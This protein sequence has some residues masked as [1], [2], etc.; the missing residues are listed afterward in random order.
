MCSFHRRCCCSEKPGKKAS[1]RGCVKQPAA[2]PIPSLFLHHCFATHFLH[3]CPHRLTV[4]A[5]RLQEHV[6]AADA[7]AAERGLQDA[8]R[9]A[10]QRP[11]RHPAQDGRA[12]AAARAQR[13]LGLP[14]RALP[15]GRRAQV[16][17]PTRTPVG[18][19]YVP[20]RGHFSEPHLPCMH[21]CMHACM[22]LRARSHLV[23]LQR[24]APAG[25][26]PLQ[27]LCGVQMGWYLTIACKSEPA[28]QPPHS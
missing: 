23:Q 9:A 12:A 17:Q 2:H 13:R 22:Q 15:R 8:A 4:C 27:A 18:V 26:P 24:S 25:A 7:A 1:L 20:M 19:S 5:L 11:H 14:L 28:R 21:V 6:R 16:T 3:S 10:A